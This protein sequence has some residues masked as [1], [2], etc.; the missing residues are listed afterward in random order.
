MV[1][2]KVLRVGSIMESFTD[3]A[4]ILSHRFFPVFPLR[5][6]WA[7]EDLFFN[8]LILDMVLLLLLLM[9][10]VLEIAWV[11]ALSTSMQMQRRAS[12]LRSRR[13]EGMVWEL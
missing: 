6:V 7:G 10:G 13:R 12:V 3:V 5:S 2:F 11:F 1:R 9:H 8:T 4:G